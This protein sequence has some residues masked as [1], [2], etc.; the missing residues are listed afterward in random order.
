MDI[1]IFP[2]SSICKAL[3]KRPYLPPASI[4]QPFASLQNI[5]NVF[6]IHK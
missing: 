5:S 1:E 2:D 4:F 6:E 3:Q